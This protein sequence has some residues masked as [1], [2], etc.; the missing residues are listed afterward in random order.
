MRNRGSVVIIQNDKV[1]LIRRIR[2]GSVYYVFPGGGIENGETPEDAA[3]RE[4]YEELG[5]EVKVNECIA[6]VDFKGTQY[7]FL[8]EIINGTFGTGQGEEYTDKERDR[9]TYMPIWVDIK[10]LSSI[11]VRPKEVAIKVQNLFK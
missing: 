9:G 11:D 10:R 7:F 5:V 4:A 3:K 2:D 6:N 8:T 1:G